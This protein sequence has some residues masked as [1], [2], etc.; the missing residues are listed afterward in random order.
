MSDENSKKHLTVNLA[1]KEA[2]RLQ[3][4]DIKVASETER[5]RQFA[6][7]MTAGIE[8]VTGTPISDAQKERMAA[9]I[10]EHTLLDAGKTE[11]AAAVN[12]WIKAGRV[13]DAIQTELHSDKQPF[14]THMQEHA[15]RLLEQLTE[16]KTCNTHGEHIHVHS[17]LKE[18]V[19]N[20]DI[21]PS[22]EQAQIIDDAFTHYRKSKKFVS[23]EAGK[24]LP[25]ISGSYSG[26]GYSGD[27]GSSLGGGHVCGS[28]CNH[29]SHAPSTSGG[30][31]GIHY[32]D[33]KPCS[34]SHSCDTHIP[35]T[36]LHKGWWIA[37]A[38]ALGVGAYLINEYGKPAKKKIAPDVTDEEGQT[39][40]SDV[41]S[42]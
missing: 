30:G 4:N 37:G 34:H 41:R 5:R 26:G 21:S 15:P 10:Q 23:A 40:P 38:V 8:R 9:K 16:K 27:S 14:L 2:I 42:L 17:Q 6:D 36:T 32:H 11:E 28:G 7:G 35:E 12:Q 33:G 19:K 3:E 18:L 1:A 31:G 20:K 25:I 39:K 24:S 13:K 22:E 29:G